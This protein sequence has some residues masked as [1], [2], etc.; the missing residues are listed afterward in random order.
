MIQQK[1]ETKE[2]LL[3]NQIEP[4]LLGKLS[5]GVNASFEVPPSDPVTR[6]ISF[7]VDSAGTF[8]HSL[9]QVKK[10]IRIGFNLL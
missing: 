8:L 9:T 3:L 10:T 6:D 7:S 5:H 1:E 2:S 4:I